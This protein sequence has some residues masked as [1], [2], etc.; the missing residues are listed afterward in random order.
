MTKPMTK[1]SAYETLKQK[2]FTALLPRERKEPPL[3]LNYEPFE[4]RSDSLGDEQRRHEGRN[5]L[6]PDIDIKDY[7]CKAVIDYVVLEFAPHENLSN[8]EIHEK[9][10]P[11][12]PRGVWLDND[13][14]EKGKHRYT[15]RI[16]EPNLREIAKLVGEPARKGSI[17]AIMKTFTGFS[18][19]NV[20]EIEVSID[21]TPLN[22]GG[23]DDRQKMVGLLTRHYLPPETMMASKADA[24][25]VVKKQGRSSKCRPAQ[26][27]RRLDQVFPD[28]DDLDTPIE[29]GLIKEELR[30]DHTTYVGSKKADARIRIMEKTTDRRNPVT[31]IAEKLSEDNKRARIEV[32]LKGEALAELDIITFKDL[33]QYRFQKLARKFFTFRLA[34]L[35]YL[36]ISKTETDLAVAELEAPLLDI[37]MKMGIANYQREQLR[38][39][40]IVHNEAKKINRKIGP[41][42]LPVKKSRIGRGHNTNMIAYRELNAKVTDALRRLTTRKQRKAV[43]L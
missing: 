27:V 17:A 3:E 37:F 33:Y 41:I 4:I 40:D 9:F 34:T 35:P 8:R 22:G 11:T 38:S 19:M 10:K 43:K 36:N 39:G 26:S 42:T 25:R 23:E 20:R 12:S 18:E 28:V 14:Y 29:R 2:K 7:T 32:T 30:V 21:F 13:D 16:Q 5:A 31:H 24:I 1:L 15:I 6:F